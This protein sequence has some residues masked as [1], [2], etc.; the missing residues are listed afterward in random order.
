M[1]VVFISMGEID[2]PFPVKML[3]FTEN[4][5]NKNQLLKINKPS[6]P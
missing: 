5:R 2:A 1:R 3:F 6:P 4:S